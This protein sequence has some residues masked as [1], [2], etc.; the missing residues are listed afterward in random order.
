MLKP[1]SWWGPG[2]S[3]PVYGPVANSLSTAKTVP[4]L[5][6]ICSVRPALLSFRAQTPSFSN[7]FPSVKVL[8]EG[9]EAEA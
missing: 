4:R 2:P 7:S 9:R 5:Q 3:V 6:G 8:L 1:L